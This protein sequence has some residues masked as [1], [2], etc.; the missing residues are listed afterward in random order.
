MTEPR[1]RWRIGASAAAKPGP[2]DS[3]WE[4]DPA[5]PADEQ[6]RRPSD[7]LVGSLL[8]EDAERAVAAVNFA[9]PAHDEIRRLTVENRAFARAA[10][11][12]LDVCPRCG[13][14]IWGEAP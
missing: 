2:N 12:S 11:W 3:I 13:D 6:G 8:R 5:E 1:R 4:Y 7:R 10:K 14:A 9:Q